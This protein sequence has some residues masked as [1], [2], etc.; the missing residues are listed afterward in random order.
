MKLLAASI[1]VAIASLALAVFHA[2][3]QHSDYDHE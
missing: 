1:T 2:Y 3:T